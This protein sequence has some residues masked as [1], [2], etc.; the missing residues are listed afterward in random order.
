MSIPIEE[1]ALKILSDKKKLTSKDLVRSFS[2][3][4][5][6]A[7]SVIRKMIK[8]GLMVKIGSTYSAYYVS[9]SD[10]ENITINIKKTFKNENL[11]EHKVLDDI[12]GKLFSSAHFSENIKSAFE[13]AFSEM[14]NNA[15][16]HSKSK[17]IVVEVKKQDNLISF[18]VNAL[19][20][21]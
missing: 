1:K 12:R 3:S 8:D 14:L 5:Q 11:E 13:Y 4:R 21:L 7:N 2:I 18:I 9:P 16:E 19:L 6:Y 10:A 17:S 20:C 15:I